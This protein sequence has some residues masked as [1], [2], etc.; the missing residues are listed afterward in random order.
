MVSCY[1]LMGYNAHTHTYTHMYIPTHTA[2]ALELTYIINKARQC[3]KHLESHQEVKSHHRT[4]PPQTAGLGHSKEVE[5][6]D[7]HE[8]S[9]VAD[10]HYQ[11][12]N[13]THIL[14][15]AVKLEVTFPPQHL[16]APLDHS[17]HDRRARKQD[18]EVKAILSIRD[19]SKLSDLFTITSKRS[20]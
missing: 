5:E 6:T 10:R 18:R 11:E 2:L 9:S 13:S 7:V 12:G 16:M 19:S 4:H 14:H 17:E 15:L 3:E 20:A 1:E 8:E